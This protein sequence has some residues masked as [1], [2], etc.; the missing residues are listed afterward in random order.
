[1][2]SE[3]VEAIKES[4]MNDRQATGKQRWGWGV[5][6]PL[7]LIIFVGLWLPARLGVANPGGGMALSWLIN[8]LL[9]FAIIAL[10]GLA[11]D[12]G[13]FGILIDHRNMMSL[14]RLQMVLWTVMILSAFITTALAR[15]ADTRVHPDGYQCGL[16]TA[17]D[18]SEVPDPNCAGPL[19][20]T[21]PPLLWTLMGISLTSAISSP[22]LK[23]FKAQR[24]AEDDRRRKTAAARTSM[25]LGG[26]DVE[27]ATYENVLKEKEAEH[28][29]ETKLTNEGA[30]VKK[31]SWM[32]ARLSD[33]YMGEEV[34]NFMYVDI[35]KV[36]NFLFSVFSVVA[37]AVALGF[38]MNGAQNMAGFFAFP[39]V[40]EGLV[41]VIGISHGGYLTDK[42]FTHAA[43]TEAP[44]G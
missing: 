26:A 38:A 37:Y 41:A 30:L 16:V 3:L 6:V 17:A 11:L 10:I 25:T 5:L 32:D 15:V 39:E 44:P 33:I 29:E 13:P 18:G 2:S 8:A 12:K 42:A 14:S 28:P 1:M 43:P 9:M 4:N 24:T 19:D 20:I 27:P 35:A 7:A 21:M 23:A 31:T 40:P 36:Q 34:A 22:L